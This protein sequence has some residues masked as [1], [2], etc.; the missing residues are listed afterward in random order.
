MIDWGSDPNAWY[1]SG[2]YDHF[3]SN[4]LS[5][6]PTPTR[7]SFT[8]LQPRVVVQF[9][10][11][12]GGSTATSLTLSCSGLP[13]VQASLLPGEVRSI[14]TNWSAPCATVTFSSS[15]GWF[16]NVDN[17]VVS[18]TAAAT[19]TPVPT[20]TATPSPTATATAT[21]T[22]TPTPSAAAQTITFDDL[23]NPD[24]VL[25]GAYP[26]GVADWGP[27]NWYLSRPW[28]RFTTNSVSF[29]GQNLTSASVM[30]ATGLHLERIDAY[31]GGTSPATLTITCAG[32]PTVS[33][34]LAADQ[35][36]QVPTGW[37]TA[38]STV[39]LATTNGWYTNFDN[40]V[41]R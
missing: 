32:Q 31:N 16:T 18:S 30:L 13:D 27:G 29:N 12:N 4:S 38:C 34:T 2:P 1:L 26:A 6:G 5:L 10:A 37:T 25:T 15:N 36:L 20:S 3:S 17:L 21:P 39:T 9:D 28:Q 11:D 24:R 14:R 23:T 19:P 35:I 7:A 8:L 22:R 41:V 40:L 33:M